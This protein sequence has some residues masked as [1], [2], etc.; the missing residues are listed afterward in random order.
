[1]KLIDLLVYAME[2][3]I[4]PNSC[5]SSCQPSC[6]WNH[7][8]ILP[9]ERA[10]CISL[11]LS[12]CDVL[13]SCRKNE[14]YKP[15]LELEKQLKVASRKSYIDQAKEIIENSQKRDADVERMLERILKD[16]KGA[17]VSE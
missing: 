7:W 4:F 8:N 16:T 12:Y 1:M 6:Y 14:L 5:Y 2:D 9:K 13:L 17:S 11:C 15:S 10:G 3:T